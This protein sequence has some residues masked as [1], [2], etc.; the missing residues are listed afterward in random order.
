MELHK[1]WQ[2]DQVKKAALFSVYATMD[3]FQV[4]EW[5]IESLP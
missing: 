3:Y 2:K 4:C 1:A 5:N